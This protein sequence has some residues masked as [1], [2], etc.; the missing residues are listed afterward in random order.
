MYRGCI[1]WS[2]S[3]FF[4]EFG[5]P[6]R[7]GRANRHAI[8]GLNLPCHGPFRNPHGKATSIPHQSS[9]HPTAPRHGRYASPLPWAGSQAPMTWPSH[10]SH[11][12]ALSTRPLIWASPQPP[13]HWTVPAWALDMGFSVGPLA[14]GGPFLRIGPANLA[15]YWPPLASEVSRTGALRAFLRDRSTQG[16]VTMSSPPFVQPAYA[17][18]EP[19]VFPEVDAGEEALRGVRSPSER[20]F[21]SR[22][23]KFAA[24]TWNGFSAGQKPRRL[25]LRGLCRGR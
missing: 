23:G 5:I 3:G 22:S 2:E 19:G 25:D 16:Y 10:S 14:M 17:S 7:F 24:A 21:A 8:A 12:R 6:V 15:G 9:A 20:D 1:W 13:C 18:R 4:E 11:T